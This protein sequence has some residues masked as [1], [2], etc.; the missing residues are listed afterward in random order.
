MSS[1]V[2]R[3]GSSYAVLRSG[4]AFDDALAER[5]RDRLC[6]AVGFS[7]KKMFGGL[8]FLTDGNM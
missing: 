3:T 5:V 8:A 4:Q 7:E 6:D 2:R 1:R